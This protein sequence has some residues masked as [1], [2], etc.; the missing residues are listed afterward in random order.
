M[1]DSAGEVR[2]ACARVAREASHVTIDDERLVALA[3]AIPAAGARGPA[4]DPDYFFVGTAED[5]TSYVV[6]FTTVNFGSGWH[7][8]VRKVPGRSG[9]ITMMT[10]LTE[11]FRRSGP[12]GADEMA[13]MSA[14][15]AAALFDQPLDAPVG[16][17][18]A[19]FARAL[20]D[21]GRLLAERFDGSAA[22]LVESSRHSALRLASTLLEM[23]MF[24]DVADYRGSTV[25]LLKRAQIAASDLSA[26][27]G[28]RGLG[29][30]DDL[31]RLTIFAD[32]L[33]PHV[34]RVEGVLVYDE[35]LAARIDAGALVPA[36]SEEEVE[37]RACAV[38]AA[39]RMVAVLRAEGRDVDAVGLDY[40][41]WSSGQAPRYKRVPRHRTRTW[42][43]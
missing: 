22:A 12:L 2:A 27:L 30:F 8:H 31:D 4:V 3:R 33:V 18:M 36:G 19:L 24:R 21:L 11:R 10:R 28:G 1:A 15:G 25:P 39:E 20:G 6:T 26:A 5:T 37:I 32:N 23:P 40:L 42:F 29:R 17:L 13:A 7:P 41:L 38:D 34:L 9:S 14:A 16:E 43:Y 35:A